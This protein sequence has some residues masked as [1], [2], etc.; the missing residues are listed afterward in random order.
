[1]KYAMPTFMGRP[2]KPSEWAELNRLRRQYRTRERRK[3]A[4]ELSGG[5]FKRLGTDHPA[6]LLREWA[7]GMTLARIRTASSAQS[8]QRWCIERGRITEAQGCA[9]D[10][11]RD[12]E[13]GK[14]W[15]ARYCTL[16]VQA[17]R[18]VVA[19]LTERIAHLIALAGTHLLP[20]VGQ[21]PLPSTS[22]FDVLAL[23]LAPQ[24]P[25]LKARRAFIAASAR[26]S[27]SRKEK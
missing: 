9:N 1:M 10:A 7:H 13:E 20:S 26:P 25:P 22:R 11:A 19:H 5:A 15:A 8:M 17:K 27:L 21:V 6:L 18:V 14:A 4:G 24:A 12:L 2:F 16:I 23:H 3:R